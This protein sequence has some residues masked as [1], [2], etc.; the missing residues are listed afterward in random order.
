MKENKSLGFMSSK[1]LKDLLAA[2]TQNEMIRGVSV[3]SNPN[4]KDANQGIM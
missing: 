2:Y 3:R 4:D 1:T